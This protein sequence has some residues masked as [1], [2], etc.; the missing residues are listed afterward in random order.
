MFISLFVSLFIRRAQEGA[1][2][3]KRMMIPPWKIPCEGLGDQSGI[4]MTTVR[5]MTLVPTRHQQLTYSL[6]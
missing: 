4:S 1:R 3:W 6:H 5:D 2:V